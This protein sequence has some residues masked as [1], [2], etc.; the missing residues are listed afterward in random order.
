MGEHLLKL[1]CISLQEEMY[2]EVHCGVHQ[3]RSLVCPGET[4]EE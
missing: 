3:S 1:D 2:V 4:E